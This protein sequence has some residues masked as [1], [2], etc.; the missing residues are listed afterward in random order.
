MNNLDAGE[1]QCS[2]TSAL[3]EFSLLPVPGSTSGSGLH[4]LNLGVFEST[5]NKKDF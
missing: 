1:V 2:L 4:I 3:G 5:L